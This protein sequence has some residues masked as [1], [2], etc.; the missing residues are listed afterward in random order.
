MTTKNRKTA[1]VTTTGTRGAEDLDY[2]TL[3][4]G[5]RINVKPKP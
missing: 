3:E 1:G 4:N 5:Q 2:V